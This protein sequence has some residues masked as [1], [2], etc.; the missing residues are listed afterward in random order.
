MCLFIFFWLLDVRIRSDEEI[1]WL[2]TILCCEKRCLRQLSIDDI[3]HVEVVLQER[4]QTDKRNY[5]LDFLQQYSVLKEAGDYDVNFIIKGKPVCREAWLLAYNLPKNSFW[6]LMSKFKEGATKLEHGNKGK[7][8]IMAKTG[9]C[10]AWLQYFFTTIGDHMPDSNAIHLPSCFSKRDIYKK[11]LEEN[12]SFNQPTVSLSHFYSIWE[13]Y[14][15][16]VTIPK[17]I[18]LIIYSRI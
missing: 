9:E 3:H 2:F 15:N 6:R 18:I 4:S 8:S 11:M 5:V 10:I 16:H 17:V 14:F 13:K 12:S 1:M 7:K